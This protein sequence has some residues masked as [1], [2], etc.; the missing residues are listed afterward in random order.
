M[1]LLVIGCTSDIFAFLVEL[2]LYKEE[3]AQLQL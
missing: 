3:T 1:T 2:R